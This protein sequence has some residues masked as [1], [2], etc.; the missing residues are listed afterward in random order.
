MV[1]RF[2]NITKKGMI[3]IL[4]AIVPF[5]V[6]AQVPLLHK[7]FEDAFLKNI[8]KPSFI[9]KD[10]EVFIRKNIDNKQLLSNLYD[11]KYNVDMPIE[12]IV[13][14]F[15]KST[16]ISCHKVNYSFDV[17]PINGTIQGEI[18]F[19]DGKILQFE[20]AYTGYGF[21]YDEKNRIIWGLGN[22]KILIYREHADSKSDSL[23]IENDVDYKK[24]QYP[25]DISPDSLSAH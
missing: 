21:L 24:F 20:Y 14:F 22:P 23:V 16:S 12:R 10:F 8:E 11:G 4:F 5:I 15:K 13:D 25:N 2:I 1:K 9:D 6:H 19:K 3:L 18:T 17:A 7:D